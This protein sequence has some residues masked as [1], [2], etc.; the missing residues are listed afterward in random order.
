MV[1]STQHVD[2]LYNSQRPGF[3]VDN[4]IFFDQLHAKVFSDF[5]ELVQYIIGHDLSMEV[6]SFFLFSFSPFIMNGSSHGTQKSQQETKT[7]RTKNKTI[8]TKT[9]KPC[10]NKNTRLT[11]PFHPQALKVNEM[12]CLPEYDS[13]FTEENEEGKQ[14][15]MRPLL[16]TCTDIIALM[17]DRD[18][19]QLKELLDGF[20]QVVAHTTSTSHH[21]GSWFTLIHHDSP[22]RFPPRAARS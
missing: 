6:T 5:E 8:A 14:E 4:I 18:P 20:K 22:P 17:D 15:R 21:H 2:E 12:C 19:T 9:R 7:Q 1:V 3:G 11:H 10:P 13:I 16:E